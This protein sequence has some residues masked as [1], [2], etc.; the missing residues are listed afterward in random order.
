[1]GEIIGFLE[2]GSLHTD[3]AS[4]RGAIRLDNV[5]L[6]GARQ[7]LLWLRLPNGQP[8][9]CRVQV[10]KGARTQPAE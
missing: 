3:H 9:A 6:G 10:L 7:D 1:M 2:T 8:L 4:N 5:K